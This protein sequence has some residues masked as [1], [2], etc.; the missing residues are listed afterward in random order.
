MVDLSMVGICGCIYSVHG[1]TS[2]RLSEPQDP[3]RIRCARCGWWKKKVGSTRSIKLSGRIGFAFGVFGII[4]SALRNSAN[5][6]LKG[7]D[8]SILTP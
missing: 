1:V 2:I 3:R 5:P 8:F 6:N 7:L 4:S